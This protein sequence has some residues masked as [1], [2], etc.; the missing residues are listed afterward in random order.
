MP[1]FIPLISRQAI[2]ERVREIG[3]QITRDYQGKDLILT[4]IKGCL[5]L[6]GRSIQTD[7]N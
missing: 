3:E 2:Q 7:Q 6:Y 5:H 4:G 1:D